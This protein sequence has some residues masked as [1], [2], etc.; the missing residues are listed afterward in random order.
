[1]IL[2]IKRLGPFGMGAFDPTI[3]S[4]P[5]AC[6]EPLRLGERLGVLPGGSGSEYRRGQPGDPV[7]GLV[8]LP[9]REPSKSH[10]IIYNNLIIISL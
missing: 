7:I 4:R 9:H 1:M 5:V 6:R 3:G 2:M 8:S 10:Q